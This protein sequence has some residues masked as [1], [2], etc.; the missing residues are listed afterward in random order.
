MTIM[1][2]YRVRGVPTSYTQVSVRLRHFDNI[3]FSVPTFAYAYKS[4]MIVATCSYL[5]SCVGLTELEK[6]GKVRTS[7]EAGW[8]CNPN[9]NSYLPSVQQRDSG[10]ILFH[11]SALNR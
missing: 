10:C 8:W 6:T 1:I 5:Q 9:S 2:D 11:W 7:A 4:Q 3:I